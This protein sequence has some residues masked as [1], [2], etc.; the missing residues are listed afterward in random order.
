MSSRSTR[1]QFLQTATAGAVLG[2]ADLEIVSRLPELSADEVKVKPGVVQ[3]RPEIEPL[4][5]F[6]EETPRE[7]LLDE[8]IGRIKRG[9]SYQELLAALQLAGVRNV[10]PRPSVG[11]KFHAV[12]VVNSAHIASLAS[13]DRERW[14]PIL[15]AVDHFKTA[16]ADNIRTREGWRMAPVKESDVPPAH[17]ARQAFIDAM[18]K[19]DIAAADAAVA[20]LVRSAG[21]DDVFELFSRFAPRDFRDIGHKAIFLAN[22]WRTLS[23]IGWQHAEPILRSLAYAMLAHRD[24]EDPAR[25]NL[26]ADRAG[27]ENRELAAKIRPEWREG[28]TDSGATAELLATL[29]KASDLEAARAAAEMFNRGISPQSIWDALLSGAGEIL[30][31]R[32]GIVGL[33]AVT[34]AN[35]L[36][37]ISET[38]GDDLTRRWTILQ[39]ASF[40]PG[41]RD[42]SISRAGG[43]TN[44]VVL[45]RLE[46]L[47]LSS[48]GGD[49]VAEICADI[50][51]DRTDVAIACKVLTYVRDNP[52]PKPL[53]DAARLLI[54]AKGNNAHD[55]KFSAAVL[56]DFY[57]VSPTWRGQYLA[58]SVFNLVGSQAPDNS[59]MQRAR[60]ALA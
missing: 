2:L 22:S 51:R 29:R 41:F 45:D 55:Y 6:I 16:Q 26:A 31:R 4:V 36:H 32:P 53:L 7:R 34:S 58:T 27:R 1:R 57:H 11:F 38:S 60:S 49:A 37:Y 8:T 5:R 23:C 40:L 30:M 33:H 39:C 13:P 15:W 44:D 52:N 24:E 19:W 12:L 14:L 35:A 48:A 50:K 17:R 9:L 42:A 18:E 46:P 10:E 20:G 43:T 56:E 59:L 25:G 47:P 28:R 21:T 3:L 54:F